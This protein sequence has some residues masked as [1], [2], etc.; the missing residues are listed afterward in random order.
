[1]N[2]KDTY[3]VV[4]THPLGLEVLVYHFRWYWQADLQSWLDHTF[5]RYSCNTYVRN[6]ASV[7]PRPVVW[8]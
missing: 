6:G 7:K 3:K 4:S 8:K 2:A 5:F 1:M